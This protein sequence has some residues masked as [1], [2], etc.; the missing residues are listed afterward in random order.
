LRTPASAHRLSTITDDQTL[1][2][3][4]ARS[5]DRRRRLGVACGCGGN[6]PP[7]AAAIRRTLEVAADTLDSGAV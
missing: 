4:P 7:G 5:R 1:A 2:I 6:G 3:V